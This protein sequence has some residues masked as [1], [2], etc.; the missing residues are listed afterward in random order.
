MQAQYR[1]LSSTPDGF[2]A[3]RTKLGQ[4]YAREPNL[5]PDELGTIKAPTVVADGEHEQ[6][7]A[8]EHTEQLA[9]LI[10]GAKLVILPDV[11]LGGPQQDPAG[12]HQ[13]VALLLDNRS[14]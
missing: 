1:A 6:F 2:T 9:R 7:I 4:L 10:P 14:R 5:T 13:A 3:L 8:R 11:S 12:F